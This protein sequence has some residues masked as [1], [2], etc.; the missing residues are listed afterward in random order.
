[1][2]RC[3]PKSF[4]SWHFDLE[5]EGLRASLGFDWFAEQGTIVVDGETYAVVKHGLMSG[6]WTME[7]GGQT[8]V[9]AQKS[10]PFTRTF[11]LTGAM[12]KLVLRAE[13]PF[14]RTFHLDGSGF[15]VATVRPDH[16]FSRRA[17]IATRTKD[18]DRP[19]VCFSFWLV[20]LTWRRNA[21]RH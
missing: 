13:S 15:G 16:V 20:A 8:V 14:G 10:S 6:H 2:I 7:R 21:R 1:M 19:T 3:T 9:E 18:F 11:E 17:T 12:G 5:G 4:F